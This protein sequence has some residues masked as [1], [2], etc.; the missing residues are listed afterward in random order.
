V[1]E[2][3]APWQPAWLNTPSISDL[4]HMLEG[5]EV[6]A[7]PHHTGLPHATFFGT[8]WSQHDERFERLAEVFSDWGSSETPDD[9]YP[10]PATEPGNF[11]RD[12]LALGYHIGLVGG[13]D[14]HG[15]RPGLNAL[16]RAGHPYSLTALTAI[17]APTRTRDDLWLALYNRRCYAA[18]TGRRPLLSFTINGQPMGARLAEPFGAAPRE[19]A[20][21]IAGSSPIREILIVKN[22]APAARFAGDRWCQRIEWTDDHPSPDRED[23]YY[24]RAE[25]SDTS[26]AW[27]SPIWVDGSA[28]PDLAAEARLWRLDGDVWG[29]RLRATSAEG[30]DVD[31]DEPLV[32]CDLEGSGALD[33]FVIEV[34]VSRDD[35]AA[36]AATLRIWTDG[37]SEPDVSA[38]LDQL[39]FVAMGGKPFATDGV[40]FADEQRED[41]RWL[42]FVRDLRVPFSRSCRVE[43]AAP[44]GQTLPRV[45]SSVVHGIW[46]DGG[47]RQLGR[48]GRCI[49][50][51]L[52]DR[53]VTGTGAALE[54]LNVT[55]R[56]LLHSLQLAMRNP[57]TG[58]QY[59]EGN[60]EIY[61]DGEERPAYASSGTEEF[62]YGGI[63]FINPFWT[64]MGGCTL[65]VHEPGNMERRTSAYR[66]FAKDPIPFDESL[67]VVWHN[68]QAGQGDVP[69][70]TVVDAQSVVYLQRDTE[71]QKDRPHTFDESFTQRLN[72]LDGAPELGP[73][74]TEI[75]HFDGLAP[76]Q[77]AT[78]CEVDGAGHLQRVQLS[79]A[80]DAPR[81]AQAH[82][83]IES[84][85]RTVCDQPLAALFGTGGTGLDFAAGFV[86]QTASVEHT[87][88]VQR[89]LCVPHHTSLAVRI[90]ASQDSGPLSGRA[91]IERR[92][93]RGDLPADFGPAQ[94]PTWVYKSWEV[95]GGP[96]TLHL[97]VPEQP[98][99]GWIREMS[100]MISGL[101]D[102][103]ADVPALVTLECDGQPVFHWTADQLVP[104][105]DLRTDGVRNTSSAVCLRQNR[106]WQALVA[107]QATPL[108]FRRSAELRIDVPGLPDGATVAAHLLVSCA[109]AGLT[110]RLNT[111]DGGVLAGKAICRTVLEDG[112]IDPGVSTVLLDLAGSGTLR[113]LRIGTP[114]SAEPL[115]RSRVTIDTGDSTAAAPV[116]GLFATW[117]DPFP[118]WQ[119]AGDVV[120]PSQLHR[121][122]G[123]HHTSSYRLM[124]LPFTGRCRVR[125]S[126]PA[127][128]GG[129]L[130]WLERNLPATSPRTALRA[131]ADLP[132]D[133][134]KG[135][136]RCAD[137]SLYVQVYANRVDGVMDWG[138]W[139]RL[140]L[141]SIDGREVKP[142]QALCLAETTGRGAVQDLQ[143]AIET[144]D[145]HALDHGTLEVFVDGEATPAW[146]SPTLNDLFLGTPVPGSGEG[147]Q[148]W[149][150]AESRGREP[151]G[152]GPRLM[153][154]AA[155]TTICTS[156]PPC[157][158]GGLR[159]F[160]RG[161]I[162]FDRSIRVMLRL[163]AEAS[164]A[165]RVWSLVSLSTEGESEA[166][167]AERL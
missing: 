14:T 103:S 106:T 96:Q 115:R 132:D 69:G 59:M 17:E 86:G 61:V 72:L 163:S 2:P 60:I 26:M 123:G 166:P 11:I 23:C 138:R 105:L 16:P 53:P 67:R 66:V 109:D 117:F 150:A 90:A 116:D 148:I 30:S 19:L 62:F 51:S 4:W 78:L 161:T 8:D 130:A 110:Q 63:Y 94:R 100:L 126:A 99:P 28:N 128:D 144:L 42:V 18:S 91:V 29:R 119:G 68:G 24:V 141:A 118:F 147:K 127:D 145:A 111:L 3:L 81:C 46:P 47:P 165:A 88:R 125:L 54:L 83:I 153:S 33:R 149:E 41:G 108:V 74:A 31:A 124:N 25:M 45:R 75:G 44:A 9:R 160:G 85:G 92:K 89:E 154:P 35:S 139:A 34:Q 50:R 136:E 10:L 114:F 140:R 120:R 12:G 122:T 158:F 7:I 71:V 151:V 135:L 164:S 82:L 95:H 56:G 131:I 49:T 137:I 55:G 87:V 155:G 77:T 64:P 107:L 134:R 38:C 167:R 97:S 22:S 102:S 143:L 27:S 39:C 36:R 70:T 73:M 113:C 152:A 40:A 98:G 157:R 93:A 37:H 121:Q 79:L 13:S 133:V 162:T 146:T 58:G 65:S 129:A 80:G 156:T 21:T 142:G 43:L 52:R 1:D 20:A 5:R 84:D 6:L 32:L 104:A 76:G 112:D 101:P 57:Q 48:M 15:S 159:R